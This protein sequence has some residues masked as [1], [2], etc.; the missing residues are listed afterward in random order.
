MIGKRSWFSKCDRFGWRVTFGAEIE[1]ASAAPCAF[2]AQQLLKF[3]V[4]LLCFQTFFVKLTPNK[5]F[6]P[7][8]SLGAWV[9]TSVGVYLWRA[10]MQI[11]WHDIRHPPSSTL[12]R[13][14]SSVEKQRSGFYLKMN[15]NKYKAS[16]LQ[17]CRV[18]KKN[19][20]TQTACC[21][22]SVFFSYLY[23]IL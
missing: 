10:G 18:C 14:D 22:W 8:S 6:W 16:D 5:C 17:W 21:K 1:W 11:S 9:T 7:W 3:G 19:T 13:L 23:W 20:M 2:I 12:L 15:Y 4:I